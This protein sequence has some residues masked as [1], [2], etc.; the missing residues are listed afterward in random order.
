MLGTNK[1]RAHAQSRFK[2]RL[3]R[4]FVLYTISVHLQ[5]LTACQIFKRSIFRLMLACLCKASCNS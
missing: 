2:A 1:D 3:S 5:K 4:A